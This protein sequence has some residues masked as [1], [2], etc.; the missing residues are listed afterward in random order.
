MED[1]S[2]YERLRL[3]NIHRNQSFL[4]SLG[5][6]PSKPASV[7]TRKEFVTP[8]KKKKTTPSPSLPSGPLRKSPRLQKLDDD[9]IAKENEPDQD[10]A[11]KDS[12][13]QIDY[14]EMPLESD[15][16]DDEEFQVYA[17]LRKWRL[18]TCRSLD[19]EPYKICQ[20]RTLA[21][22]I[23]RRRNDMH[24]AVVSKEEGLITQDLLDCWGL[25]P[26][27]VVKGGYG[28][29][30]AEVL[31]REDLRDLLARSR[32]RSERQD[33]GREGLVG[34]EDRGQQQEGRTRETHID[35]VT[36]Q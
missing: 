5:I 2:E 21:E 31:E 7:E 16:L 8:I 22:L 33:E 23:R 6:Q 13:F 18:L 26:A 10:E 19:T 35:E 1:L 29:Q 14:A 17:E 9:K 36:A 4:A 25:G 24:W 20:N 11:P 27:K 28:Y 15:E 32:L 30:L 34:S 3:E 12:P